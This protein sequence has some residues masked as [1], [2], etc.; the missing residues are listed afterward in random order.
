MFVLFF[1]F[2]IVQFLTRVQIL[3]EEPKIIIW[4][5]V[6]ITKRVIMNRWRF[7]TKNVS[8]VIMGNNYTLKP[9]FGD[10]KSPKGKGLCKIFFSPY[11]G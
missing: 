11:K 1:V 3:Q 4:E 8:R 10:P 2:F 6:I 5:R 7:A 9:T